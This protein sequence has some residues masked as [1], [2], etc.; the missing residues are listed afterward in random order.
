VQMLV[1]WS[2][3]LPTSSAHFWHD[4][5]R[6]SLALQGNAMRIEA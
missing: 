4:L 3:K 1:D 2:V 6:K 5:A